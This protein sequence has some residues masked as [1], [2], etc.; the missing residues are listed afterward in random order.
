MSLSGA[1]R[2]NWRSFQLS[3]VV[4]FSTKNTAY[5]QIVLTM[6]D[7]DVAWF[8]FPFY[9]G[10]PRI[11]LVKWKKLPQHRFLTP[12]FWQLAVLPSMSSRMG[13]IPSWQTNANS[14]NSAHFGLFK[15]KI[16]STISSPV[17]G[18]TAPKHGAPYAQNLKAQVLSFLS[19]IFNVVLISQSYS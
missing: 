17:Q 12:C 8:L 2:M 1:D 16:D 4:E 7:C 5:M 9:N 10:C 11:S 6:E 3:Q 13:R 19:S 15:T 14:P 18:G